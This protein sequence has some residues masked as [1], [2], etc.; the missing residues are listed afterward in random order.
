MGRTVAVPVNPGE[1]FLEGTVFVRLYMQGSE[2]IQGGF[3]M[4]SLVDVLDKR[5]LK[6]GILKLPEWGLL[7]PR[8]GSLL[9]SGGRTHPVTFFDCRR[10]F[11]RY[12][13]KFSKD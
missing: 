12:R 2:E 9:E 11:E 10:C 3:A 6:S 5:A 13:S 4:P 1:V 8:C 7:C